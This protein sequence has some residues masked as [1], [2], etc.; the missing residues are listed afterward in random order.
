MNIWELAG[1]RIFLAAVGFS[2]GA[3]VAGGVVA[4]IIGLGIIRR[5][6]GI[7]HTAVHA[8]I[9]E[10][11][12]CLGG[13]WGNIMTVFFSKLPLGWPGLLV[14]GLF[15]GV[16]VGG[17]IMALAEMLNVFPVFAR[18][19]GLTKGRSWIVI[20]LALGKVTGSLLEFYMRWGKK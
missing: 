11:A 17:W 13:I 19:M 6:V 5:F 2:A 12:I 14:M 16:F 10:T 15:S 4:L 3:L 20:G 9:Y 18:R 8:G 1:S 7:S